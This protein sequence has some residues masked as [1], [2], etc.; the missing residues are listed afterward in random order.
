VLSPS[1]RSWAIIPRATIRPV[2][3]ET[4]KAAAIDTPLITLCPIVAAALIRPIRRRGFTFAIASWTEVC[5]QEA[6]RAVEKKK[7]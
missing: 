7:T 1:L 2:R 4:S 3:R 5:V 6:V